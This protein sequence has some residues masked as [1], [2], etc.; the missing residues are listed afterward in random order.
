MCTP[1]A[2]GALGPTGVDLLG[3]GDALG[4]EPYRVLEKLGL[5]DPDSRAVVEALMGVARAAA[6]LRA[7]L[8]SAVR[9]AAAL[10]GACAELETATPRLLALLAVSGGR[11]RRTA[12]AVHC[13]ADLE[14]MEQEAM[15]GGPNDSGRQAQGNDGGSGGEQGAA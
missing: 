8:D 14:R 5:G 9:Q 15:N 2:D 1:R 11:I 6:A 13:Q 10:A 7:S 3:L 4:V 12:E